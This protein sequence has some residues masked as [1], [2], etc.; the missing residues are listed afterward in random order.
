MKPLGAADP[1]AI[2]S[3][4]L[5]GVL[6]S[7]GMGRVYLAQSATGRRLAIKVIRADLA[8]NP[9]FRRRFAHEVAAVRAVNPLFTAPVV[10]ADP[11]AEAPWLATTYIDG[12]SLEQW[13]GEHGPLSPEAVLTLAA[14][15]AE[16]LAS[17]HRADLVHRDLKPGNVLL[18]DAGPHIIDFGI[19]QSPDSTR[20]TT[21]LVGTPSYMA[22]ERLRGAEAAPPAD[23]FSLGATLAFAATG[24]RLADG[25]NMYEQVLQMTAGR[26]D[27]STVPAEVRRV[28]A[29]CV[30]R[31][32]RDRPSAAELTRVL[33]TM[34][35]LGAPRPGWY[36]ST[37]PPR[38][39]APAP[40]TVR[41]PR[42]RV[43]A[44]GGA[45]GAVV[46]GGG[47][48][49]LFAALS[50]R[51][52]HASAGSGDGT[53]A[54]GSVLWQ[55]R[56]GATPP[57]APPEEGSWAVTARIAVDP[58]R[59]A[60]TSSSSSVVA[61]GPGNDRRWTAGIAGGPFDVRLWGD[62]VLVNDAQR[63]WLL[64]SGTGRPRFSALDLAGAEATVRGVDP[65]R[66]RIRQVA[67]L[68]DRAF[69]DLS[70]T[71][72]AIDRT[73]RQLW[74]AAAHSSGTEQ[75]SFAALATTGT[76]LVAADRSGSTV[77]V[78]AYDTGTGATPRWSL[79][80]DL[81]AMPTQQQPPPGYG[82]PPSGFPPPP[83]DGSFNGPPPSGDHGFPPP[84][85]AWDRSE[86]RLGKELL[87]L[88]NAQS[89]QVLRVA[90]GTLV[91]KD[92]G[93][94]PVSG[95]E[96][97]GDLL[98][99]A[100]D[101][102]TARVLASGAPAWQK[103]L[104]NARLATSADGRSTVAVDDQ[105][106]SLLD[107]SG[108]EQWHA[109][110]PQTVADGVPDQLTVQGQVGYLTFQPRGPRTTPLDV[111]VLAVWLGGSGATD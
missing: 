10:D 88:R 98:V 107:A 23:V 29:W 55:L 89:I 17:I 6:G 77:R 19:A 34:P 59:W 83:P 63:V 80:Y 54:P 61:V 70:G 25:E 84:D 18:D 8:D 51:A 20:M 11:E 48:A 69:L 35:E 15:L 4:R 2:A 50:G 106:I 12:P 82:P 92:A 21:S 86:L 9:V 81:P 53:R 5:L 95:I 13:V 67:L 75:P 74:R 100:G 39:A 78:S 90:D 103:N 32:A 99:V 47:T 46:L 58:T 93:S 96:I 30:N 101:T 43:I 37:G 7:G 42:R 91:W 40:T 65:D 109:K 26:F 49:A 14:G 111:D 36:R 68:P 102:L 22:P 44:L 56:S 105:G 87:A 73:G 24:R 66:V 62:G 108:T 79:P 110:L 97:A 64:D 85:A 94:T 27:L 31:K 16:A 52:P 3:Y 60:V 33:S 104:R 76:R 57:S 45:L 28:V 1:T 71:T 38:P 41:L 72:V